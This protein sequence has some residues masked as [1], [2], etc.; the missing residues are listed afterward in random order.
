MQAERKRPTW[1]QITTHSPTKD[2]RPGRTIR[3]VL[4]WET[5]QPNASC[6]Q[7]QDQH[8]QRKHREN[9]TE[10]SQVHRGAGLVEDDKTRKQMCIFPEMSNYSFCYSL[11]TS[12]HIKLTI[13]LIDHST[14][15]TQTYST[16][17][18]VAAQQRH[19]DGWMWDWFTEHIDDCNCLYEERR[20]ESSWIRRVILHTCVVMSAVYVLQMFRC[21]QLSFDF[22]CSGF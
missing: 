14:D 6:P 4:S 19:D 10:W 11:C 12:V 5:V 1:S 9:K 13:S 17:T 7:T 15:D 20:D 16:H 3:N 21:I 2:L 18:R 22:S 8:R